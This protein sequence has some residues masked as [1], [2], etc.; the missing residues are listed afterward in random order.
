MT[1]EEKEDE[2]PFSLKAWFDQ[3]Q[4]SYSAWEDGLWDS[5]GGFGAWMKKRRSKK[6]PDWKR[7]QNVW[8]WLCV[9]ALLTGWNVGGFYYEYQCNKHIVE[10]FYPEIACINGLKCDMERVNPE[11]MRMLNESFNNDTIKE[12]PLL[13]KA[14]VEP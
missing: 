10:E 6:V 3:A 1:A 12:L 14:E 13:G 2:K 4:T 8:M 5:L 7:V 11:L 9:L